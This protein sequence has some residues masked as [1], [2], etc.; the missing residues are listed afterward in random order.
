MGVISFDHDIAS[1]VPAAKLFK[2]LVIDADTLVPKILPQAIKCV[3]IVEGDGGAGTIKLITFGEGN[4]FKS[5]THRVDGLDKDSLTYS[6]SIVEGD[7]LMGIV[8]SISYII[9]VE[10]CADGSSI[11]KNKSTYHIKGDAQVT[12]D[13][14]K[15]GEE[16]ALGI[17]K[18]IEG[19]LLANPD[20]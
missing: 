1:P 5:M 8:E 17:F 13:Q 11:F 10:A 19:Y 7:V 12:E 14:I 18:A 2:A 20:A 6:Y 16:K 3:E 9:K 4:P 15:E